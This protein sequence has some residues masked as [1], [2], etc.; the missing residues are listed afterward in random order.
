M[1]NLNIKHSICVFGLG[2]MQVWTT[3]KET[4]ESNSHPFHAFYLY[5]NVDATCANA[6]VT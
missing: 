5:G 1:S 3:I 2:V 6:D 4:E